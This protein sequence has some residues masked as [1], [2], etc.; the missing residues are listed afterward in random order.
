MQWRRNRVKA[1]VKGRKPIGL[2]KAAWETGDSSVTQAFGSFFHKRHYEGESTANNRANFRLSTLTFSLLFLRSVETKYPNKWLTSA[3][4]GFTILAISPLVVGDWSLNAWRETWR[5]V[6]FFCF[7]HFIL[8]FF[9]WS[10]AQF[11]PILVFSFEVV[12]C[13]QSAISAHLVFRLHF[14]PF[15]FFPFPPNIT[16]L[17][18]WRQTLPPKRNNPIGERV[19]FSKHS[20]DMENPES[21]FSLSVH[22][23]AQ[24]I[25]KKSVNTATLKIWKK[26]IQKRKFPRS[27]KR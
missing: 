21:D 6:S 8:F 14:F 15:L 24:W 10:H 19:L 4:M 5:R 3:L 7:R 17:L 18:C 13:W 2:W 16:D 11:F 1:S 20:V 25:S 26:R 22:S 12:R 9:A 27:R 23:L